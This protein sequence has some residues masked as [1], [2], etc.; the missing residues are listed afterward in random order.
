[1]EKPLARRHK[2]HEDALRQH[3]TAAGTEP[4]IDKNEERQKLRRLLNTGDKEESFIILLARCPTLARE[5]TFLGCLPLTF[6]LLQ[7]VNFQVVQATYNLYPA[8]KFALD[9]HGH[10][11]EDP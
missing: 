6:F 1:M 9:E 5:K 8:A 10:R 4:M 2:D 7:G 3:Y 11:C